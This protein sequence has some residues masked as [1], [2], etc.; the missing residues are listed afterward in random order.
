MQIF[1]F[2]PFLV[3]IPEVATSKNRRNFAVVSKETG[4]Y[5]RNSQLQNSSAPGITEDY[6][7]QVSEQ[8][9]GK[10]TGK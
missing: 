2:S 3:F 4:E 1:Q 8:I 7:A 10:I 5:P 9:E 6:E